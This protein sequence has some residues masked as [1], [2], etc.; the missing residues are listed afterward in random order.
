[1][2]PDQKLTKIRFALSATLKVDNDDALR[3]TADMLVARLWVEGLVIR[4]HDADTIVETA[5]KI[6]EAAEK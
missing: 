5:E 1:M 3:Q 6:D 4:R 2:T